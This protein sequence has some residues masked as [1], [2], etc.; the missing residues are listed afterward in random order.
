MSRTTTSGNP[1]GKLAGHRVLAADRGE[2]EGFLKVSVAL[3]RGARAEH[4]VF[5]ARSRRGPPA[6][7][8]CARRQRTLTAA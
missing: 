8:R 1:C 4:R 2:R 5:G 7:T 3:D 6:R